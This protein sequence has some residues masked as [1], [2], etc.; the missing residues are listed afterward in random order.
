MKRL[1][2]PLVIAPLVAFAA[3][4]AP[5]LMVE[6]VSTDLVTGENWSNTMSVLDGNLVMEFND[7][8]TNT[9]GSMVFLADQQEWIM[10]DD[11]NQKYVRMNQATIDQMAAQMQAMMAQAEQML[12]NLPEA[13]REMIMNSGM[14]GM[15]MLTGGGLPVIEMRETGENDTKEGYAVQRY[16]MYVGDRL[17]QQM[18][19]TEWS[20]VDGAESMRAAMTGFANMMKSFLE[21]MPSGMFGEGGLNSFMDFDRGIPI[22]TYEIDEEGNPAVETVMQGFTETDIDPNVFGPK[23]GYEEQQIDIPGA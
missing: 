15:E 23:P 9:S 2:L 18:W 19:I 13:Q 16:D 8:R 21:A 6:I 1:L 3:P 5:G 22:V 4:T 10:N 12:A 14:P 7:P 11:Q 20:N 17:T